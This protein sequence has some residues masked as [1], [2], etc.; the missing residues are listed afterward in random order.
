MIK[1]QGAR[2]LIQVDGGVNMD[3]AGDLIALGADIL[4]SGSA[5]FKFPPYATR[6]QHYMQ[7]MTAQR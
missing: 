2:T 3:N 6:Y 4:V 1:N 7:T 5:F